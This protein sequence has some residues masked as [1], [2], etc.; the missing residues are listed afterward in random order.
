MD[1]DR[2]PGEEARDNLAKKAALFIPEML[3]RA[4]NAWRTSDKSE[5]W[6]IDHKLYP[7]TSPIGE[8]AAKLGEK[9][10]E[11]V[12]APPVRPGPRLE[13]ENFHSQSNRKRVK[14]KRRTR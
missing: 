6:R 13:R 8:E 4:W 9:Y 2:L 11:Y 10:A 7:N 5:L 12:D 1:P 14:R 3:Y